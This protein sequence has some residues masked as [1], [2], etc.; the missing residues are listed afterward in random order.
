MKGGE[1]VEGWEKEDED[2]NKSEEEEPKEVRRS[3]IVMS[4]NPHKKIFDVRR[5]L[6]G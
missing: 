2:K 4:E 6:S 3:R 1:S 5:P